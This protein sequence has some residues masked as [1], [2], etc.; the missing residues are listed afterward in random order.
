[1]KLNN[2]R[3]SGD[4]LHNYINC[5][6]LMML[7][8]I[9]ASGHASISTAPTLNSMPSWGS[10]G[11]QGQPG[12]PQCG[13]YACT[14]N[15][16]YC[17]EAYSDFSGSPFI[18]NS[19]KFSRQQSDPDTCYS[20]GTGCNGGTTTCAINKIPADNDSILTYSPSNTVQRY[21]QV[22]CRYLN[23]QCQSCCTN[24]VPQC[25]GYHTCWDNC[26][27]DKGQNCT[28]CNPHNCC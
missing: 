15:A 23:P 18:T 6:S 27:D 21:N 8:G 22:S 3:S 7:L 16:G 20:Y 13:G 28:A 11:C 14:R 5:L 2:F 26:C 4:V 25:Y 17:S 1:M 9:G 24:W 12:C 10:Q 19:I